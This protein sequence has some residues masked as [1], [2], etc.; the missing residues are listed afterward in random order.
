MLNRQSYIAPDEQ[1][2][3]EA[4]R[5]KRSWQIPISALKLRSYWHDSFL[6]N[7]QHHQQD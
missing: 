3:C 7:D 6:N 2:R 1:V 4:L 5:V